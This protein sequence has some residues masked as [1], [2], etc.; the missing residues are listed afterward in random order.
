[1]GQIINWDFLNVGVH[2]EELRVTCL[3]FP[4]LHLG[5]YILTSKIDTLWFVIINWMQ[6]HWFSY[7]STLLIKH[8]GSVV[9]KNFLWR[10]FLY[11]FANNKFYQ[12]QNNQMH[13]IDNSLQDRKLIWQ[14]LKYQW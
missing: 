1:M 9:A 6:W 3:L 7:P 14:V 11:Q 2:S 8:S 13:D 12:I 5:G 4:Y 10:H